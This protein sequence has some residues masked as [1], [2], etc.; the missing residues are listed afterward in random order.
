MNDLE[1][2]N[3]AQLADN[4]PSMH[5]VLGY[6]LSMK[7]DVVA[8]ANATTGNRDRRIRSLRSGARELA[9]WLTSC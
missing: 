2:G 9:Q 4:F 1:L 7:A 8:P 6:I 5:K 3:A